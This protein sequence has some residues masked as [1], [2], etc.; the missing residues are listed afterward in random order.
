MLEVRV[1]LRHVSISR[2]GQAITVGRNSI[3]ILVLTS[4]VIGTRNTSGL[5][6]AN[7]LERFNAPQVG[8]GLV[9]APVVQ[10]AVLAVTREFGLNV[11]AI[12]KGKI[13]VVAGTLLFA[14]K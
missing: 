10:V 1:R 4:P 9:V 2:I 5:R 14:L 7:R 6:Y 8:L 13:A 11:T 12:E 3:G